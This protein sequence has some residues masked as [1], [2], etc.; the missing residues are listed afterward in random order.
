ML[1]VL[2]PTSLGPPN[3]SQTDLQINLRLLRLVSKRPS[4]GSSDR[5]RGTHRPWIRAQTCIRK[6]HPASLCGHTTSNAPHL[7]CPQKQPFPPTSDV[8]SMTSSQESQDQAP[9]TRA[10]AG[11]PPGASRTAQECIREA[12]GLTGELR[13]LGDHGNQLDFLT[14]S[15]WDIWPS[16]LIVALGI[17]VT[18]VPLSIDQGPGGK[19]RGRKLPQR[20]TKRVSE[21][22]KEVIGAESGPGPFSGTFPGSYLGSV[23][24]WPSIDRI[25]L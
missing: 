8:P 2:R 18:R 23:A 24:P 7:L 1:L 11:G 16:R 25:Q 17:P 19:M 22:R 5:C 4:P 9:T 10:P 12:K 6:P 14:Q 20:G 13:V 15:R 21:G 3:R